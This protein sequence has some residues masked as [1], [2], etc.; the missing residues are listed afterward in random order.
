MRRTGGV[1][2]R[3]PWRIMHRVDPVGL[4]SASNPTFLSLDIFS[5]SLSLSLLFLSKQLGII[6]IQA[7]LLGNFRAAHSSSALHPAWIDVNEHR[8]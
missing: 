1:S 5:L 4:L 8:Q 6:S 2:K 3:D 7:A